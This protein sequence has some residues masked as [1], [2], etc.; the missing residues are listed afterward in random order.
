MNLEQQKY[1]QK[2]LEMRKF[3]NRTKE[4]IECLKK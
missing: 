3:L 4:E 1:K 2:H